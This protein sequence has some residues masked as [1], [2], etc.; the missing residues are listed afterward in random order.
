MAFTKTLA[1]C[2][3]YFYPNNH[4]KAYSWKKYDNDEK[5]AAFT[6][7][8]RELTVSEGRSMDDPTSD[9]DVY[10]DDYAVYEQSL[11]IL[12]NTPRQLKAG[13]N[14][15]LDLAMEDNKQNI[16]NY[17]VGVS[18]QAQRYFGKSRIQLVRG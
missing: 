16:D 11:Y 15:V 17:G 14:Q 9:D 3:I 5:E 12:E 7:A 8:I 2:D 4:I 13:V 18:P 1:D 6:Q 10:R